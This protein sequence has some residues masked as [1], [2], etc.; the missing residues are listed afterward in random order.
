MHVG[1]A[2]GSSFLVTRCSDQN[3]RQTERLFCTVEYFISFF[4]FLLFV[5]SLCLI[6]LFFYREVRFCWYRIS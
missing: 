1:G 2:R 4:F 3:L 6:G 5:C